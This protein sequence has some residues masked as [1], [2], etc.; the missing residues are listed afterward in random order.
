MFICLIKIV[1]NIKKII[2]ITITQ[3]FYAFEKKV[4]RF[5]TRVRIK[6]H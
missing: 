4:K 3:T 1:D 6:K 2:G 5:I